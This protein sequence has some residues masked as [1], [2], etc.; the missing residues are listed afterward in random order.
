MYNNNNIVELC[1][2]VCLENCIHSFIY[3]FQT[4]KLKLKCLKTVVL[5]FFFTSA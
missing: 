1:G 5:V 2:W 4:I 3:F